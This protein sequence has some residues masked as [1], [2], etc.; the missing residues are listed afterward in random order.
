MVADVLQT[1][2]CLFSIGAAGLWIRSATIEIPNPTE[3]TSFA[4]TGRFP[5]ALRAQSRWSAAA[6]VSGAI[7]AFVQ[8]AALAYPALARWIGHA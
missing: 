1:L 7:A 6:A 4:G 3:N 8:A 2:V 5:D